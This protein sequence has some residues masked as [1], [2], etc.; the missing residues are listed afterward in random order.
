MMLLICVPSVQF[1]SWD[2]PLSMAVLVHDVDDEMVYLRELVS[3]F[4]CSE[5]QGV[6]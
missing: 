2:G 5:K 4:C 1:S 6:D 3:K